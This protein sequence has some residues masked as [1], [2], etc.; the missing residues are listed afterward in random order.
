MTDTRKIL[1][2]IP[3][4]TDIIQS[5]KTGDRVYLSGSIYT[6]RDAAH[7]RLIEMLQAGDSTPFSLAGQVIY[8]V[9]PSPARPGEIIGSAGPTTASRVD[10]YT[11]QLLER[12]L[13]GMIGKGKRNQAVRDAMQMH[14]AVYFVTVGGAAALVAQCIKQVEMVAYPDLGTEAIRK[15][16]VEN[17]PLVVANDV[18]GKDLFEQGRVAYQRSSR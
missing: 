18:H 11:P 13:K 16:V 2:Q 1:L 15:L 6:A 10:P 5:L 7:K 3:L 12:G 17:F 8:Y 9:G 4:T 14:Q